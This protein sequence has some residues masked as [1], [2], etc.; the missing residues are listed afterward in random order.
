MRETYWYY[1]R[2]ANIVYQS[3][4]NTKS[5][6]LFFVIYRNVVG[7]FLVVTTWD[8]SAEVTHVNHFV[9]LGNGYAE[10]SG[11]IYDPILIEPFVITLQLG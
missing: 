3:N 9:R 7:T 4:V 10:G 11:A 6:F 2:S 1:L 5:S 8:K